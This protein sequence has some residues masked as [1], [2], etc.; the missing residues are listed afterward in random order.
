MMEV[1]AFGDSESLEKAAKQLDGLEGVSA[2]R[3]LDAARPGHSVLAAVAA[4]RAVETTLRDLAQLGVRAEDTTVTRMDIVQWTVTKPWETKV[5]WADVLGQAWLAAKP[6]ANYVAFMVVAG[7]IAGYG[8]L[9]RNVILIVGAMAISPDLLPT[10]AAAVGIVGRRWR[11][12]G[13]AAWTFALGM[14]VA[15]A[16]AALLTFVLHQLDVLPAGFTLASASSALG[17]LTTVGN[18]TVLV[19]LAAGLGGML[20]LETAA[21]SA[22]G[23]AVSVT[24]IPAAAYLGVAAGIG[25]LSAAWG[26]LGVL[27]TNFGMMIAGALIALGIQR[28]LRARTAS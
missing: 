16:S 4:P 8:V 26:A 20:A 5:A 21:S 25:N 6:V 19:A 24:T 17:G 1:Q 12:V 18:E 15:C 22:V 3:L 27:G 7:V 2:V 9:D 14:A 23:V 11:L 28:S 10:M 13:A